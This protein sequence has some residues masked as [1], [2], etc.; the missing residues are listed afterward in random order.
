[1]NGTVTQS[2]GYDALG[3]ITSRSDVGSYTYHPT[4]KHAVTQAGSRAFT[5]DANGNMLTRNGQTLAWR[6][7][8]LPAL[9]RD[10]A[11]SGEPVYQ[12][13]FAYGPNGERWRQIATFYNGTE[14]TVSI[15][16]L[17]EKSSSSSYSGTVVYRHWIPAPD[18]TLVQIAVARNAGPGSLTTRYITRD[19][20]GSVDAVLSSTAEVINRESFNVWGSRRSATGWTGAPSGTEWAAI[21]DTL[22]QGYTS[23]ATNHTHLD[24]LGLIHMN[25]RVL[26]PTLGRFISADP[27]IPDPYS[28]QSWNRYSYVRNNYLSRIDPTGFEDEYVEEIFVTDTP[29]EC[30]QWG[31]GYSGCP[32]PCVANPFGRGCPDL[33]HRNPYLQ[34]GEPRDDD[35]AATQATESQ[36]CSGVAGAIQDFTGGRSVQ[37]FANDVADNF[38]ATKY[39]T[40]NDLGASALNVANVSPSKVAETVLTAAGAATTAASWGG[41]TPAQAIGQAW[42]TYNAAVRVSGLIGIRTPPQ[43]VATAGAS[44]LWNVFLIKG[45]YNSGVLVGSLLRTGA[46]R[47]ATTACWEY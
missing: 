8:D 47:L 37:S 34:P 24:N 25:G 38:M 11:S 20:L 21:A 4:R 19:H 3:N 44:W 1:M 36:A 30:Q 16:G 26:D 28:S 9:V 29:I 39:T 10:Q 45:A 15:A 17:F 13:E 14:T 7:D 22:R 35:P 18:G 31:V 42:N 23:D 6:G 33:I 43:L 41:I 27:S 46:N 32:D 40:I 12:S 5:Y 2:V